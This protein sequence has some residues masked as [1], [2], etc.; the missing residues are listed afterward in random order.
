[1]CGGSRAAIASWVLARPSQPSSLHRSTHSEMA[2]P[3]SKVPC[4]YFGTSIT[5]L[6][7]FGFDRPGSSIG[8][9]RSI[10]AVDDQ[11][12]RATNFSAALAISS[13]F[14]MLA[15]GLGQGI[16]CCHFNSIIFPFSRSGFRP[17]ILP[18]NRSIPQ[19]FTSDLVLKSTLHH[20]IK[21]HLS[22]LI[23]VC[24]SDP[25]QRTVRSDV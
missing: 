25:T 15:Q 18:I 2:R 13:S 4:R 6:G 12:I 8:S 1:M 7:I 20:N 24:V 19:Y 5:F 10:L 3:V 22:P 17:F 16:R 9:I 23:A 11:V 14:Q 21:Y